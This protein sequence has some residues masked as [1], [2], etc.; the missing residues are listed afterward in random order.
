MADQLEYRRLSLHQDGRFLRCRV[1]ASTAVPEN[2]RMEGS[3]YGDQYET[4]VADV[5]VTSATPLYEKRQLPQVPPRYLCRHCQV[6]QEG[7][8]RNVLYGKDS[9]GSSTKLFVNHHC[10][11]A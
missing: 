5:K 4:Y 1:I 9:S 11:G 7:P 10:V 6:L 2:Q 3:C 8:R